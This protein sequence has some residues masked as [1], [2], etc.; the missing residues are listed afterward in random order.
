MIQF[1]LFFCLCFFEFTESTNIRVVVFGVVNV[2]VLLGLA[3]FQAF[4]MKHF[5][6]KKKVI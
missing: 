1:H 5:L 4:S 3:G 2:A 6:K